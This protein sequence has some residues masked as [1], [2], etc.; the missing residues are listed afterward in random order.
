MVV[1]IREIIIL[2]L[3]SS[4]EDASSKRKEASHEEKTPLSLGFW[5]FSNT[6]IQSSLLQ[7]LVI[8]LAG[9][10]VLMTTLKTLLTESP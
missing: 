9:C 8:T 1:T 3:A 2:R 6:S 5:S 4:L 7:L 10:Q